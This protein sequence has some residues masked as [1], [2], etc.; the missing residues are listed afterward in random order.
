MKF[1][2]LAVLALLGAVS[3][4]QLENTHKIKAVVDKQGYVTFQGK[5]KLCKKTGD[6][7][8]DEICDGDSADNKELEKTSE[9]DDDIVED[10][11]FSGSRG[12]TIRL[13]TGS[14]LGIESMSNA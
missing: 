5:Q 6:K 3:A 12:A 13:Q 14:Q 8:S 4:V 7:P 10:H 9:K 1:T 2:S 11:G